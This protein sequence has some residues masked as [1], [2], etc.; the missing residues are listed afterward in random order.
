MLSRKVLIQNVQNL[1]DAR[2]FAAWGVEYL[3]FTFK[4]D[5]ELGNLITRCKEIVEW[6]EG[7]VLMGEFQEDDFM[8]IQAVIDE[9]SLQAI[10]HP[11]E[12]IL[13]KIPSPV[14]KF[15]SNVN[16]I[17]SISLPEVIQF[18]HVSDLSIQEIQDLSSNTGII[19]SSSEEE[20]VGFK[21]YDEIDEIFEM[22][23]I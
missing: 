4:N 16:G 10:V 18:Q 15:I 21:S 5:A 22:L 12:S 1:T 9:L 3:S 6:V 19:L 20:K 8:F 13:H 7:P 2:Y 17:Y 11:K 23:E 14:Q